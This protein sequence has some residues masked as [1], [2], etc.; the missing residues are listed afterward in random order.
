MYGSDLDFV[1]ND[2]SFKQLLF[3]IQSVASREY[4]PKLHSYGNTDFQVTRGL[5]GI[6][7]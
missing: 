6:S 2:I 5:L 4:I 3:L 7:L 1:D